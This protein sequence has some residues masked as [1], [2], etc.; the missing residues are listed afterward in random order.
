MNDYFNRASIESIYWKHRAEDFHRA[1]RALWNNRSE[2]ETK[3][4]F[5]YICGTALELY[6][7][8]CWVEVYNQSLIIEISRSE[9]KQ[10]ITEE[11][12]NNLILKKNK[13]LV[14]N[15][16]FLT[17]NLNSII[18]EINLIEQNEKLIITA[19]EKKFLDKIT[20]GIIWNSKYP[21]PKIL[22][23]Y[24]KYMNSLSSLMIV[25]ST[26]KAENLAIKSNNPI[27]DINWDNY[28]GMWKR[29]EEYYT[30]LVTGLHFP[31]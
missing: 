15:K 29:I 1:A 2:Y 28:Q 18:K 10:R 14:V 31:L 17:H 25:K 30:K 5:G 16:K 9:K 26:N 19:V 3:N 6:L 12:I 20:E 22:E 27:Y 4:A 8:T 21:I 24:K 7:K 11:D 23:D 13:S